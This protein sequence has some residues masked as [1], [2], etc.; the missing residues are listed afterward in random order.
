VEEREGRVRNSR[1]KRKGEK[2]KVGRGDEEEGRRWKGEKVRTGERKGKRRK[3]GRLVKGDRGREGRD[4][5]FPPSPQS[6]SPIFPLSYS[7]SLLPPCPPS[8]YLTFSF[9]SLP[10]PSPPFLFLP[11][12]PSN[13]SFSHPREDFLAAGRGS[14][15]ERA[16]NNPSVNNSLF[17]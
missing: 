16:H 11:P 1:R 4:L 15:R 3:N 2:I 7:L 5:T 12:S 10:F 13:L 17:V 8:P 9:L 14:I 6:L